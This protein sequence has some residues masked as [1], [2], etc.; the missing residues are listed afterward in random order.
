M[1]R[2]APRDVVI[3]TRAPSDGTHIRFS[4]AVNI[5]FNHMKFPLVL[6]K[7]QCETT[8]MY[9]SLFNEYL[10][11]IFFLNNSSLSNQA[12]VVQDWILGKNFVDK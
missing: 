11:G 3:L 12:P 1:E 8:R 7:K 5:F 4:K 9:L 2:D 10:S 6:E